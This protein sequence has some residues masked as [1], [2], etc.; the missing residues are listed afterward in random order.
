MLT[1]IVG[2]LLPLGQTLVESSTVNPIGVTTMFTNLIEKLASRLFGRSKPKADLSLTDSVALMVLLAHLSARAGE[3]VYLTDMRIWTNKVVFADG[4]LSDLRQVTIEGRPATLS[5]LPMR[6][7]YDREHLPVVRATIEFISNEVSVY[8]W[9]LRSVTTIVKNWKNPL[10]F[11]TM[12]YA[13]DLP[14]LSALAERLLK[15]RNGNEIKRQSLSG[16]GG[17]GPRFLNAP[18]S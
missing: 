18:T 7:L 5:E 8:S 11:L 17:R 16:H 13:S 14:E 15:H 9:R 12:H 4:D 1:I 2:R 3:Q 6:G 10:D